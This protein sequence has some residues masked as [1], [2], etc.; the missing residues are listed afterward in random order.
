MMNGGVFYRDS[1]DQKGPL[2]YF[3]YG[4]AYLLSHNTFKG[5]FMMEI[6]SMAAFLIAQYRILRLYL[7]H[8]TALFFV[9]FI[10][11][12]VTSCKSFY[13]GGSAEE[14]TLPFLSWGLYFS[15]KYFKEEYPTVMASKVLL[16]CGILAGCVMLIK[17]TMLGMYFFWMAMIAFSTFNRKTW[18]DSIRNCVIFLVGMITPLIPW[19][20]Y[21]GLN[22]ALDDWY[23]AYIYCNVF[24]YSDF[25]QESVAIAK[26][27]YDLAKILYWLIIDNF[28]YFSM[29]ILGFVG[30]LFDRKVKWY[31]KINIYGMFGFLF[32]GIFVGG[33]TLFY[34]SLPLSLFVV[35]GFIVLGKGIER[36]GGLIKTPPATRNNVVL[37]LGKVIMYVGLLFT[38][39]NLSMN[40]GYAK[41]TGEDFYLYKFRDIILQE[42]NP[43]LLNIGA[44]DV[45]LYTVADVIPNCKYF[46]TNMVHGFDEVGEQQLQYIKE[47]K[48]DFIVSTDN[49]SP[50][51]WDTY[52][53]VCEAEYEMYAGVRKYYLFKR[54]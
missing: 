4:I 41:E 7:K 48:I 12:V 29:I 30:F 33:T 21:F 23:H 18:R 20:I 13:W 19:L 49:Y 42:E 35:F 15:L 26:K 6:I 53:L 44:L 54:K 1:F 2:L 34:Y 38:A 24:F 36:V 32:L 22:G 3:I 47:G 39:W 50:E 25:N 43:T 5:V 11:L 52:E 45:G 8:E 31:E 14:F 28:I 16:F 40:T 17:Y 27:I 51:I 37:A 46:Q 10:A 9:P